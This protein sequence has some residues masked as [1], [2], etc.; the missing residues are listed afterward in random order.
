[1]LSN[2]DISPLELLTWEGS[3]GFIL[4]SLLLVILNHIDIENKY[5]S[6]SPSPPWVIENSLD[7]FIQ[8]SN[9]MVLLATFV[10]GSVSGGIFSFLNIYLTGKI[11]GTSTVILDQLRTIIVWTVSLI[12]EWQHFQEL[13]LLGFFFLIVGTA[14]YHYLEIIPMMLA[15]RTEQNSRK[16]SQQFLIHH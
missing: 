1:M 13:A 12:L 11:S 5:W 9:N 6:S 4:M 3:Y 14:V 2:Y 7:G 8:L 16:I 15:P 10:I